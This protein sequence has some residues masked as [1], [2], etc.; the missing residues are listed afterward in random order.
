MALKEKFK[1]YVET[2]IRQNKSLSKEV[3]LAL[4]E[5]ETKSAASKNKG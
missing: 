5:T 4:I 1:N 3:E 2:H